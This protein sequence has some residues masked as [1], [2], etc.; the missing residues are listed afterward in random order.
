[1]ISRDKV[2]TIFLKKIEKKEKLYKK[3]KGKY[4]NRH[5][6]Y[7]MLARVVKALVV[8]T[9]VCTSEAWIQCTFTAPAP[10]TLHSMRCRYLRLPSFAF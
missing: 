5:T 3:V 2:L 1:M 6:P 7:M 8:A 4:P 9:L 10:V